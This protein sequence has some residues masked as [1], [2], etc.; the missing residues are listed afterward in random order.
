MDTQDNIIKEYIS[1]YEEV[2][3]YK[4]VQYDLE[5][6]LIKITKDLNEKKDALQK[7]ASK[8]LPIYEKA[9]NNNS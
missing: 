6:K 2:E 9:K 1:I 3:K 4:I 5:K 8:L 7:I